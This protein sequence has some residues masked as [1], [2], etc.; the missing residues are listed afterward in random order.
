MKTYKE[1]DVLILL[2]KMIALNK[3]QFDDE[4]WISTDI[5]KHLTIKEYKGYK[6]YTSVLM[7]NEYM[8]IGKMY[9]SDEEV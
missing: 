2:D 8:I 9:F 4:I 7:P 1:K 6:L 3:N 5:Y